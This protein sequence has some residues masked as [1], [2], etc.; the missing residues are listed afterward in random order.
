MYRSD[1]I[2]RKDIGF[3]N[4]IDLFSGAKLAKKT[5]PHKSFCLNLVFCSDIP[6]TLRF[7]LTNVIA[8]RRLE[9]SS[10]VFENCSK[11]VGNCFEEINNCSEKFENSFEK[12][13]NCSRLFSIIL[14]QQVVPL[15]WHYLVTAV[16]LSHHVRN[17]I[18][19]RTWQ[20]ILGKDILKYLKDNR[21]LH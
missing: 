21:L 5:I 3:Q 15:M 20:N 11:K 2:C 13:I 19:S 1:D 4:Y 8:T 14:M 12:Y 9:Y 6:K 18:V 10:K 17:T 7:L 16:T